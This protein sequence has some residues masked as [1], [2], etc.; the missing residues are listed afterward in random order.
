MCI[1]KEMNERNK[2][3]LEFRKKNAAQCVEIVKE[4]STATEKYSTLNQDFWYSTTVERNIA[5]RLKL[6]D[7]FYP[8][9]ITNDSIIANLNAHF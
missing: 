3:H 7:V 4:E 5:P 1:L 2:P 8:Q 9:W 6:L